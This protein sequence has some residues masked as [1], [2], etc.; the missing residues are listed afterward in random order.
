MCL[1]VLDKACGTDSRGS[2]H[3][4]MRVMFSARLDVLVYATIPAL[5]ITALLGG[6]APVSEV[7]VKSFFKYLFILRKSRACESL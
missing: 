1:R 4:D 3:S 6:T 7:V 2:D 5:K